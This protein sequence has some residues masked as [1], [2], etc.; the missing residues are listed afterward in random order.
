MRIGSLKQE[1]SF[2][3]GDLDLKL[4]PYL[5]FRDGFFIEVGANDGRSF[6]NSLYFEMYR[7][8][9]GLL[10]EPIPE[11]AQKCR[12]NRP[13]C[14][15]ENCA[16]VALDYPD[17]T[18][19]MQYCN[20]MSV[21]KGG[22]D[23]EEFEQKHI[24]S[25]MQFLKKGEQIYT[26]RVPAKSLSD[27]LDKHYVEHVD[28]LS[29]DVEGYESQVLKGLDLK[30]HHPEFMLIEVRHREEVEEVI[31][32]YYKPIAILNIEQSYSDILY[33]LM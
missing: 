19:D 28:L 3:L 22:G 24:Q 6:S 5:N 20:L 26:V 14:I 21:V 25:G 33:Q 30:R 27:V 15:V 9:K 1:R 17:T 11:L 32:H 23:N 29:L 7:G 10:I 4:K 16:L 2:A 31:R 18:I 12:Q 8:W 13:N